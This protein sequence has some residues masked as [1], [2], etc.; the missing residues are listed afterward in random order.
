[1]GEEGEEMVVVRKTSGEMKLVNIIAVSSLFICAACGTTEKLVYKDDWEGRYTLVEYNSC[2]DTATKV[3]LN[4]VRTGANKYNWKIFFA[5]GQP[6]T[7][8]GEALY[9]GNK[10]KF[11]V[12]NPEVAGRYFVKTV[13]TGSAVFWME[14]HNQSAYYTWWYNE[15]NNYR[16]GK[17]LFAGVD[18]HFKRRMR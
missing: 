4:V 2:C 11:S 10:L 18:Y 17:M 13:S 12:T 14:Y 1:V 6:D 9:A 3:R 8:K 5:D 16:R 15:M 7:I